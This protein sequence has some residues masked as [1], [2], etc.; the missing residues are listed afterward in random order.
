MNC[1]ILVLSFN[2]QSWIETFTSPG[3]AFSDSEYDDYEEYDDYDEDGEEDSNI[4]HNTT[5][6]LD[7]SLLPFQLRS[8]NTLSGENDADEYADSYDC[9]T[10]YYNTTG[11]YST[12]SSNEKRFSDATTSKGSSSCF[13]P[14]DLDDNRG[15][16]WEYESYEQLLPYKQEFVKDKRK[17]RSDQPTVRKCLFIRMEFYR[18]G[19]LDDLIED[20]KAMVAIILP[21]F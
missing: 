7:P 11:Q 4:L 12:R 15:N 19:T 13:S 5:S 21:S 6:Q 1:S 18:N 3:S 8:V 17:K 16:E 2:Q 10:D 9:Y 20:P 14:T